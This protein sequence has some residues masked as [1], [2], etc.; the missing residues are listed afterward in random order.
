M[1][2]IQDLENWVDGVNAYEASLPAREAQGRD[3]LRRDRRLRLH[4]LDLRQRRRRRSA[5]TPN[6]SL[7]SRRSSAK[8]AARKCSATSRRS[9]TPKRR[10]PAPKRSRTTPNRPARPRARSSSN[11]ARPSN[12]AKKAAQA[13]NA[14]RRKMS[15]FLLAGAKD[16]ANGHPK[17]V[18]GPQLGYYYPE[19]VFQADMHAPGL[20]AQGVVAPISPYVFIGRGKDFA[21]SL[22]SADS[23]NTQEFLEQLCNEDESPPTRESTSYMYNGKCVPMH[24]FDA[25]ELGSGR[26]KE[27]PREVK[28]YESVHGPISGT[29]LV[30]GQPYAIAVD[31]ATRGRE[32]AGEV[33]FCEARLQQGARAAAVLRS[34]QR[35]RDDVQHGLRRQRTHRVLLDGAAADHGGGH[36]PAAADAGHGRIRLERLPEPRTAPA[37]NRPGERLPDELEQQARA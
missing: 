8:K 28:F 7:A 29:V 11:R 16:A 9:T 12:A 1:Q 31:R 5:A 25:G 35:T 4:R 10:R 3:A 17:A 18:M 23:E 24:L 36:Q 26:T 6:S 15:N 22:T 37:R 21:W 19:I 13:L 33:A 20:D 30:K 27:P 32:P 14:S 34:G 2:V